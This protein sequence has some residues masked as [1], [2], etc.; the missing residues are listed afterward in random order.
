MA[1]SNS[2]HEA[3]MQL[4]E[5]KWTAAG[6]GSA[7]MAGKR[8]FDVALSIAGLTVGMPLLALGAAAVRLESRGGL[9]VRT[10]C[11]GRGARAFERLRLRT[12]DDAGRTTRAGRVLCRLGIDGLPQLVNVLRSEMSMVG[13]APVP[14]G[15]RS[16]ASVRHLRRFAVQP[17][18]A[19][20]WALGCC[21]ENAEGEYFSPD[22]YYRSHWS[23]W[24]DLAIVARALGAVAARA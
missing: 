19:G 1:T 7:G 20:A 6:A 5:A 17:G 3:G 16:A 8:A 10:T 22:A 21:R 9:L 13:P 15:E 23:A 24:L 18:I 2:L 11:W 12:S 4:A 14:A